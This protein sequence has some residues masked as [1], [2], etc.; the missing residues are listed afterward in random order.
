MAF[1]LTRTQWLRALTTADRDRLFCAIKSRVVMELDPKRRWL[2][3][4]SG[5]VCL[6]DDSS[7][8]CT[9]LYD[10]QFLLT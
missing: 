5:S 9:A 6:C 7:V 8:P 10:V 4:C 2:L 3:R 1:A